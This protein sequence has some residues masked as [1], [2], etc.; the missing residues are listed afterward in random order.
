MLDKFFYFTIFYFFAISRYFTTCNYFKSFFYFMIIY[1]F[2]ISFYFKTFFYRAIFVIVK[3]FF[4]LR[5]S[6]FLNV[7]LL[8]ALKIYMRWKND[9]TIRISR[10]N[11]LTSIVTSSSW[12]KS[13]KFYSQCSI[14]QHAF[15]INVLFWIFVIANN[16]D[17]KINFRD[18]IL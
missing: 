13:H 8:Y 6:M 17:A 1:F 3:F 14:F 10:V 9:V 11:N 18:Q 15:S 2:A 12:H 16:F 5:L 4:T 7:S